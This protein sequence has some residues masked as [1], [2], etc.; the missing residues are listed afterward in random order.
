MCLEL[1]YMSGAAMY[2]STTNLRFCSAFVPLIW[3]SPL[4]SGA[5]I[6]VSVATIYASVPPGESTW[7]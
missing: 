2:F 6:Y 1:L 7:N 3:P 5:A 4:L